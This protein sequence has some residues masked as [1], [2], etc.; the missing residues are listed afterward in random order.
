[1]NILAEYYAYKQLVLANFDVLPFVLFLL[2]I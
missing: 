2:P 1:M